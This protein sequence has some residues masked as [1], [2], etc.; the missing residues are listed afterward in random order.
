MESLPYTGRTSQPDTPFFDPQITSWESKPATD[1]FSLGSVIYVIMTRYWP[2]R[3]SP[4][5]STAKNTE[6]YRDE[7]DKLF[8]K[9]AFP[10]VSEL[11]GGDVIR[12]C[13]EYRYTSAA[14]VLNDLSTRN[15]DSKI[16]TLRPDVQRRIQC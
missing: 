8:K 4:P 15:R 11:Q 2:F 7:V 16:S 5:P 12:G 3:A 9:G 1:I 13:W 10:D 14:E 6:V